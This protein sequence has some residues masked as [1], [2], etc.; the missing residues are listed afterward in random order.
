MPSIGERIPARLALAIALAVA[1]CNFLL[2]VKWAA[3][4]GALNGWKRPWYAAA[5]LSA[6][7][8]LAR[9][10]VAA[11][12]RLPGVRWLAAAASI[13]I[14]FVFLKTFPPS[15]W[16]M[17]VFNDDWVP[18]YQSTIDGIALLKRGA[19]VGW[20]WAFLGGYQTSA[21][22]TQSLTMVAWLPMAIFG[23]RVGFH[24][25][26]LL[27]V[28]GVPLMVWR[29]LAEDGSPE[30][31]DLTA[32]LTAITAVGMFGTIVP[33][34]DTNSIAGVFAAMVALTGSRLARG[35]RR[36][37]AA[38]LVVGL[39]LALYSH[40]A[41][42]GYAL[43]YL[44]LES[45]FYRD[46]RM[47]V[48]AV[49]G[50]ALAVVASLPQYIELIVH[51]RYF[52]TNNLLYSPAPPD[53]LH[54]AK[55]VYYNTELLLF[56]H[57]WFNDYLSM[58][59][60]FLVL[61]VWIAVQ[62]GRSRARF[63]SWMVVA[64][65]VLLRFDVTEAG[66]LFAR[67]MHML[68][69]ISAAPLA[70]F[71]VERTGGTWL[72]WSLVAIFALYPH[73]AMEP[74]AHVNSIQEFD[75]ALVD[76]IAASPGAR[77]LVENSPHRDLDGDPVGRTE[78]TPFPAH[79]EAFLPAATGKLIYGQPWDC[80]HWTPFRGEVVAG[81]AFRGQAIDK[82][83]IADFARDMR[84]WGV[85]RLLVWSQATRRYLDVAPSQFEVTWRNGL[86]VE[87]RMKEADPR[88]VVTAGGNGTLQP[89]SMLDGRVHLTAVTEGTPVVV[90]ANFFPAW[91]A[92]AGG[93][94]VP[95]FDR[96]GQLAFLAPA[97]G[98][99]DVELEYPRR[100]GLIAVAL[101]ALIAGSYLLSLTCVTR[102]SR[103][104]AA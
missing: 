61:F 1:W 83:A 33:S 99:Y 76:R 19:V 86:W 64:T 72:A 21:D 28:A 92:H 100:R 11:R 74:L 87:Y 71:V 14:V 73:T 30:L 36:W 84:K 32:F 56:P 53:L 49:L 25:L 63:Y 51:H 98:D 8:L 58:T 55:Q 38:V 37:G 7:I 16:P 6:S 35:G 60:V 5:L 69:A 79:F 39:T 90:R 10:P 103:S 22:L 67:E 20:Q 31:A 81:G 66:F 57:R 41:F 104:A 68:A 85:E 54:V 101:L 40:A 94:D 102:S 3:F 97:S 62:P 82:T 52:L 43:L 26:H 9:K 75:R 45:I 17:L 18:R 24:L 48:R 65:M 44:L 80:W 59:K 12:V 91:T 34:G 77:V 95:L 4:P 46:A 27:L 89:E 23:E 42:F 47:A 13:Y 2:T 29:D 96:D 50:A 15:T 78:R 70:W 93:R 88:A